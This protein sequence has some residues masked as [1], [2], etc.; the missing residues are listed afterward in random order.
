MVKT[1]TG[2]YNGNSKTTKSKRTTSA[3]LFALSFLGMGV[4]QRWRSCHQSDFGT[5]LGLLYPIAIGEFPWFRRGRWWAHHQ[6][7]DDGGTRRLPIPCFWSPR[8]IW[9]RCS[10]RCIGMVERPIASLSIYEQRIYCRRYRHDDAA[11]TIRFFGFAISIRRI[12]PQ[13]EGCTEGRT[14]ETILQGGIRQW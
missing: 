6:H 9:R 11:R 7:D 10:S 5:G 14:K 8:R 4:G 1:R 3:S 13:P 2:T 12:F